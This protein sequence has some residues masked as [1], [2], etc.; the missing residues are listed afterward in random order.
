MHVATAAVP[1]TQCAASWQQVP[2]S[3]HKRGILLF[4][5]ALK[6]EIIVFDGDVAA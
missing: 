3:L 2:A 4:G 5:P 6:Q 1:Q